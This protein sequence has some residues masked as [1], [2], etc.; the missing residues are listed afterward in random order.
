MP[1]A[2]ETYARQ[3][4]F[5]ALGKACRESGIEAL[6]MGH[7][8]DDSIET[9]LWRLA[10]GAGHAGLGGIQ[11]VA[12]FPECHGIFGVFESGSSINLCANHRGLFPHPHVRLNE[13][14]EGRVSFVSEVPKNEASI[15]TGGILLCRPLLAFPK[16]MLLETCHE[17]KVPYVTDP[18]NFDPTLTPRNAIR[19]MLASNFMPR[20][21]QPASILSLLKSSKAL[22]NLSDQF[23]NAILESRCRVLDF[24]F[25][26]GVMVIQFLQ[27]PESFDPLLA[28]NTPTRLRQTQSLTLRRITELVSPFPRNHF[29]LRSFE[30]GVSQIFHLPPKDHNG[31][32]IQPKPFTL[33]GVMLYP[34][35]INESS[36]EELKSLPFENGK[37]WM[38]SRQPFI[39]NR[40]PVSRV[41][42]PLPSPNQSSQTPSFSP[43]TLWDDRFWLRFSLTK[44]ERGKERKHGQSGET[45]PHESRSIPLVIRPFQKSDLDMI[46]N[47][48]G[49]KQEKKD[50]VRLLGQLKKVLLNDAPGGTRFTIPVLGCES[51]TE[52]GQIEQLLVLPTLDFC[53]S[54]SRRGAGHKG[55]VITYEGQKWKLGWERMYKMIDTG[56]LRLMEEPV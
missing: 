32:E 8:R 39:K 33:G 46:R 53:L 24:N 3:L 6:L 35:T 51:S 27:T 30:Q 42:V 48:P 52:A 41:E 5:Q 18:T 23:S 14:N 13:K 22:L 2:F 38:F 12:R 25:Q 10:T 44:V 1:T 49:Q 16:T 56:A 45:R 34:L 4:R 11:E 17:N 31:N 7:H 9:A 29:S 54:G 36:P 19:S 26:T 37:V 21:L 55:M 15:A 47:H 43:W 40:L 20:A 28:S 50:A